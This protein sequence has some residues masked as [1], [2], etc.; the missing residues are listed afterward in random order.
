MMEC[1]LQGHCG[2]IEAAALL[3]ALRIKGE[4]AEELASAAGVMRRYCQPFPIDGD[5]LDTCG[6]VL[7]SFHVADYPH[8]R[9]K[10]A[11]WILLGMGRL[12]G[13]C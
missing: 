5:V 4:T 13:Q 6:L 8:A 9:R 12:A 10:V 11:S 3:V 2:E 1:L 7:F